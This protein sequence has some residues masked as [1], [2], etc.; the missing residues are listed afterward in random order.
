MDK[1]KEEKIKRIIINQLGV[2]MADLVPEAQLEN[3]LSM[4]SL[5]A[6]E[7][8]MALEEEFEIEIPDEDMESL[9]TVGD[10]INYIDKKTEK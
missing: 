8:V 5:D 4:D 6:V 3:D 1:I 7:L 10:I 2:K 9:L